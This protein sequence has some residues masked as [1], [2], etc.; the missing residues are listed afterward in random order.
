MPAPAYPAHGA[1]LEQLVLLLRA[2]PGQPLV[3]RK[4]FLICPLSFSLKERGFFLPFLPPRGCEKTHKQHSQAFG[5]KRYI[6]FTHD[7]DQNSFCRER[8]W[9]ITSPKSTQKKVVVKIQLKKERKSYLST[10]RIRSC[11]IFQRK[12]SPGRKP[13]PVAASP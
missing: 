11:S 5:R 7:F 12:G 2:C 3:H 6:S 1:S 4:T 13:S 9:Q 8:Q 10:S